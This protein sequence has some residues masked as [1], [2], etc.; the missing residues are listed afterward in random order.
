MASAVI[1]ILYAGIT[2]TFNTILWIAIGLILLEGVVLLINKWTCPLTPLAEKYTSNREPN[3]DIYL[4]KWLAKHN[5]TIFTSLFIIG[6]L[7]VIIN[8]IRN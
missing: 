5:K 7:L 8:L 6:L 3:F 4:P 1:Y 2:N